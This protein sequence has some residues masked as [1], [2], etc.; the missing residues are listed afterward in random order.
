MIT[1]KTTPPVALPD[2]A[3]PIANDLFLLKYVE[4]RESAGQ[5]ISP[6]PRP[7]QIP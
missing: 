2:A 1:G 7:V 3:I 6:F 5:K 4:I